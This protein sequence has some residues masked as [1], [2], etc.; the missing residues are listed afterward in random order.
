MNIQKESF[1]KPTSPGAS[2][3]STIFVVLLSIIALVIGSFSLRIYGACSESQRPAAL[4]NYYV[5]A[6]AMG[7]GVGMLTYLLL[8]AT[9]SL[10]AKI[11]LIVLCLL[12]IGIGSVNLYYFNQGNQSVGRAINTG[13]LGV[14]IG[15]IIALSLGLIGAIPVTLRLQILGIILSLSVVIFSIFGINTYQKCNQPPAVRTDLIIISV[16]LAIALL[17]LIGAIGSFFI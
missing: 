17:L 7:F 15:L 6:F 2:I 11:P 5:S 8:N 10:S 13:L 3:L 9:I 16:M 14:G 4:I 12:L 1:A